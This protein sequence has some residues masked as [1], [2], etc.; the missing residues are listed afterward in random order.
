MRY[1]AI[2][3]HPDDLELRCFG[4][5]AKLKAQGHEIAVCNIANGCLGSVTIPPEE[6]KVIRSGE[7]RRA[8]ECI[9]ARHFEIGVNDMEV[10]RYDPEATRRLVNAIRQFRPDVIFMLSPDDYHADHV[11]ASWLTF[12]ASF[13]SSLPNFQA[14]EPCH[15]V[16]P[17]LYYIDTARGLHFE[18]TEYVNITDYMDVRQRAFQCHESQLDWLRSHTSDD[19]SEKTKL[20]AAFRG[21]QCGADYAEA[22]RLCDRSLRVPSERV[23]P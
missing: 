20:H 11:E 14:D 12:Y 5:L 8:A 4:T 1:M 19:M 16:V 3:A 6:L 17:V 18:P 13:S 10:N 9:G 23:L 15:P 2:G 7:A 21:Y 22:F